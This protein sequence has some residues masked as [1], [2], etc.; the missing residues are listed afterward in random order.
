MEASAIR[1]FNVRIPRELIAR[2]KAHAAVVGKPIQAL[3][4]ETLDKA[5]PVY[6]AQPKGK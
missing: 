3:V 5:I 4:A 2:V 1:P 6:K